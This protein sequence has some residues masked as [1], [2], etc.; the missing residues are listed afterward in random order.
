MKPYLSIALVAALLISPQVYAQQQ[1]APAQQQQAAP[2][3]NSGVAV[4]KGPVFLNGIVNRLK[5]SFSREPAVQPANLQPTARAPSGS[6][7][8]AG[9]GVGDTPAWKA[10]VDAQ[11]AA[12]RARNRQVSAYL[13]ANAD[14]KMAERTSEIAAAKA[15]DAAAAG[16][17][18]AVP[19]QLGVAVPPGQAGTTAPVQMIYQKADDSPA[20]KPIFNNYR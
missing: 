20:P 15:A 8:S 1:A 11:N 16:Q 12:N 14:K 3:A 7:S 18:V 13:R 2:A 17:P 5:Q 10:R 4:N 9:R 19:G 6:A